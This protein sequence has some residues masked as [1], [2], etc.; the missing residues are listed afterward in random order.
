MTEPAPTLELPSGGMDEAE[1]ALTE[2][3]R[4]ILEA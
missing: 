4:A 3:G 2:R 1:A